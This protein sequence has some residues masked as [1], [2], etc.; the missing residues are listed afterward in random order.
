M[1]WV[2]LPTSRTHCIWKFLIIQA[3]S[4]LCFSSSASNILLIICIERLPCASLFTRC[5]QEWMRILAPCTMSGSGKKHAMNAFWINDII[6]ALR[7]CGKHRHLIGAYRVPK[8]ESSSESG[9]EG[10][11]L[12]CFRCL[13]TSLTQRQGHSVLSDDTSR[14]CLNSYSDLSSQDLPGMLVKL[15][16]N[17]Y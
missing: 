6:P 15:C 9:C 10:V 14:L 1:I 12:A 5:V 17:S 8:I 11:L 16:L 7:S 3:N 2:L 4:V 13:S